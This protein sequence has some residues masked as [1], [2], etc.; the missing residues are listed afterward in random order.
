MSS[1]RKNNV[2][3]T[4]ISYGAAITVISAIIQYLVKPG[5]ENCNSMV[6]IVTSYTS[7]DYSL[8]CQILSDI[9][10][11]TIVTGIIGLAIVIIGIF[12]K[13]KIK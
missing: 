11:G 3:L 6:G 1:T 9:Q 13:P 10:T 8:G 5:I 4:I 12:S 2:K 7:H